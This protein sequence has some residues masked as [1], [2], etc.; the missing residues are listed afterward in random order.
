MKDI[1]KKIWFVGI[2]GS[3]WMKIIE[4]YS[5][6]TG[7]TKFSYVYPY[8]SVIFWQLF[9]LFVWFF[10]IIF[11]FPFLFRDKKFWEHREIVIALIP[12]IY[13]FLKE[14]WNMI[15]IWNK[16]MLPSIIEV[17]LIALPIGLATLVIYEIFFERCY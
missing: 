11:S 8:L 4:L 15:F 16:F 9:W 7:F 2:V 5:R 6:T 12:A 1:T 10:M 14:I 13:Y 17:F 3:I